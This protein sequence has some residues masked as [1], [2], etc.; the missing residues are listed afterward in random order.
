MPQAG[1]DLELPPDVSVGD[2]GAVEA[3]RL[4]PEAEPQLGSNFL[5]TVG[6]DTL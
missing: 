4:L 5:E 2:L 1:N 6:G 3:Q